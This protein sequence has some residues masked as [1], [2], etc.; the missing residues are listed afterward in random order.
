M[1]ASRW[2]PLLGIALGV[3]GTLAVQR[4]QPA[5]L[6][7]ARAAKP[8]AS[9]DRDSFHAALDTVLDR[10][11][12][13]VDAST[14]LTRGLQHM[15]AG[16]DPYSHY[17]SADQRALAKKRQRQGAEAGLVTTLHR[18][19]DGSAHLEV[20]AVH[21]E[22]PG[23][24]AGLRPGDELVSIR[25]QACAFMASNVE[26]QLALAGAVGER[27]TVEL[28]RPGGRDGVVALELEL[29]KPKHDAL[30]TGALDLKGNHAVAH[31]TIAA[32]RKGTGD[33]V[34]RTLAKLHREASEGGG[35]LDGIVLDVRGN[36]GGEVDEAVIVA[37]LFIDEGVLTRTRARGGAIAR[38]DMATAANSDLDTPLVVLQDRRS[39]SASELLAIA[40]QDSG[41]GRVVGETSFGKGTV[42]EVLPLADGS[43]L[44]L[45]VARYYSPRDRSIDGQG[46]RPDVVLSAVDGRAAVD[47][48]ERELLTQLALR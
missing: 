19:A 36:P 8:K 43:L 42:Q 20:L 9:L 38:E 35:K 28:A 40:I 33:Q 23:A 5:L 31:I 4:A 7:D 26:A 13:P 37:D 29:A 41:R 21:P 47:A 22:S 15:V 1:R 34:K 45:T 48:A 24:R 11:V 16:L 18:R 6:P 14:V 25:G 32:F 2:S 30:V 44:T 46:V 39:A 17:L 10:Y 12:E 3:V 27:I